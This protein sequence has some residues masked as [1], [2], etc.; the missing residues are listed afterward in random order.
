MHSDVV[1]RNS[2]VDNDGSVNAG[3]DSNRALPFALV[4]TLEGAVV[5]VGMSTAFDRCRPGLSVM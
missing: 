2:Y 4:A 5:T 1:E 3:D